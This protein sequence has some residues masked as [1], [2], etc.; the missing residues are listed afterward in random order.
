MSGFADQVTSDQE[1]INQND[2]ATGEVSGFNGKMIRNLGI[3]HGK[4]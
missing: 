1:D 4:C 2:Y 3:T